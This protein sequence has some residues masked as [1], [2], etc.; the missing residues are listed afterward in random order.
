[1]LQHSWLV[2]CLKQVVMIVNISEE[3]RIL[4]GEFNLGNWEILSSLTALTCLCFRLLQF[5][6]GRMNSPL[7]QQKHIWVGSCHTQY[8]A[9]CEK[10]QWK[11]EETDDRDELSSKEALGSMS[12][13]DCVRHSH[14]SRTQTVASCDY[15]L[16]AVL[17]WRSASTMT[18]PNKSNEL[19]SERHAYSTLCWVLWREG[20]H[21]VPTIKELIFSKP[22]AIQMKAAII[23]VIKGKKVLIRQLNIRRFISPRCAWTVSCY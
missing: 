12:H 23:T 22:K 4:T 9:V 3:M 14:Q 16:R 8:E 21:L 10:V 5:S 18:S 17:F 19:K 11:E 2:L 20:E 15:T 6:G 7:L 1:M 13:T